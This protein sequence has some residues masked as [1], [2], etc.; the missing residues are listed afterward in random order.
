[1]ELL[2]PFTVPLIVIP[3]ILCF[4]LSSG[5]YYLGQN[6]YREIVVNP[7][8]AWSGP[9]ALTLVMEASNNNLRDYR[10]NVKV[11]A[12][13]YYPSVV[14]AIGRRA[15]FVGH[16]DEEGYRKFVDGLLFNSS[17]ML[18][19]WEKGERIFAGGSGY[20]EGPTQYDSLTFLISMHNLGWPCVKIISIGGK[21]VSIGNPDCDVPDMTDFQEKVFLVNDENRFI[22]PVLV[23]GVRQT[24]LMGEE[25]IFI[26]FRLS[27]GEHHFL[28]HSEKMFL[29]FKGFGD[30]IRLEYSTALM[31]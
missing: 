18:V 16:W 27:S 8:T 17:G 29:V 6:T 19:D 24:A 14:K 5:C 23:W 28:E 3:L 1:M 2:K 13:P 11:I 25:T 7:S 30:D 4:E 22:R 9:E 26:K 20:L 31:K 12:T 15:Q 10:N 21:F